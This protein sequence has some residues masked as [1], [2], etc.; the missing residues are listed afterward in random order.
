MRG[1]RTSHAQ[2]DGTP[3]ALRVAI[4]RAVVAVVSASSKAHL[5]AEL[6]ALGTNFLQVQPGDTIFGELVEPDH[7][8]A[9]A[10]M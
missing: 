3:Q 9:S 7:M 1:R 4:A 8:T 10:N 5:I 6:D 2:P